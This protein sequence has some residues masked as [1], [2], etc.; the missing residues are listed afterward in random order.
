[1]IGRPRVAREVEREF[2]RLIGQGIAMAVAADVIGVSRDL[3][4]R[5]FAQ[6]GGMSPMDLGEPSGRYLCLAEREEIAIGR[7]RG[8]GVRQI[9]RELGRAPSTISR[10]IARNSLV[11]HPDWKGTPP[12]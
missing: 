4:G 8:H 11:R 2:W 1:M 12:V 3:C 10:E 7:A 6:A 9:A 5:W